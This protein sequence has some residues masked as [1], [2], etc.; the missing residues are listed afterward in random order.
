MLAHWFA[1]SPLVGKPAP[2]FGLQVVA[3]EPVDGRSW[4]QLSETVGRVVVLDF[5]ASWCEACRA[6]TPMLNEVSLKFR[7]QGVAFIGVNVEPVRAGQVREAH[8]A[9]G[10][11]FPSVADVQGTVQRAFAV[12]ALPTVVVIDR[13]G[14]VTYAAAGVPSE[15]GLSSAISTALQ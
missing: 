14:L 2:D 12:R 1:R 11:V 10:A 7:D 3:G 15:G 8:A 9:F 4:F 13:A 5:W 6:S